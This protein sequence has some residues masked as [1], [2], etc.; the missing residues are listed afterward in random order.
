MSYFTRTSSIAARLAAA[1]VLFTLSGANHALDTVENVASER[2]IYTLKLGASDSYVGQ[3]VPL[4]KAYANI[5]V[6]ADIVQGACVCTNLAS[7]S[8]ICED[9][10]S[11]TEVDR[12]HLHDRQCQD[13][14]L[15]GGIREHQTFFCTTGAE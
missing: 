15:K 11:E 10:D 8:V 13:A 2:Q 1:C 7:V 5:G 9:C 6:Q 3:Q 12:C 14:A 4:Q